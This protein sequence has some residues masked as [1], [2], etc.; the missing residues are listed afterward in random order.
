M[1]CGTGGSAFYLASRYGVD[2]HGV[3]VSPTMIAIANDYRNDPAI[4]TP[5]VKHRVHFEE[6]DI[7]R[8]NYRDNYYDVIFRQANGL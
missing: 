2:V 6:R 1:G 8:V 3:D 7:D 5:S 4:C